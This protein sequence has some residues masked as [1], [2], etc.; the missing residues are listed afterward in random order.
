[1]LRMML[2]GPRRNRQR[3]SPIFD[4]PASGPAW[5]RP[6]PVDGD[7]APLDQAPRACEE[8]LLFAYC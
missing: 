2:D 5:G 6:A 1:M 4:A 7:Y 8:H 3:T